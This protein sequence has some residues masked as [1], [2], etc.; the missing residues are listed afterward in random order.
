MPW[1]HLASRWWVCINNLIVSFQVERDFALLIAPSTT[2]KI[3]MNKLPFARL[4][5]V[6]PNRIKCVLAINGDKVLRVDTDYSQGALLILSRFDVYSNHFGPTLL[7]RVTLLHC[8]TCYTSEYFL[9]IKTLT[10]LKPLSSRSGLSFRKIEEIRF[11]LKLEV[12]QLW[13]SKKR[14]SIWGLN[15]WACLSNNCFN[16][17]RQTNKTRE[18]ILWLSI[19]I[20]CRRHRKQIKIMANNA[21][22]FRPVHSLCVEKFYCFAHGN[23]LGSSLVQALLIRMRYLRWLFVRWWLVNGGG[24]GWKV[25]AR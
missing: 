7:M 18:S 6:A 12:P 3:Q 25:V 1:F 2:I 11:Q 20:S 23:R 17:D 19:D 4:I 14:V 8:Y 13:G 24:G 10:S 15:V 5:Q 21:K 9:Y 16:I 22:T